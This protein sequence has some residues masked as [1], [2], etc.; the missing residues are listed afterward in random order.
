MT[1]TVKDVTGTV[2]TP[3]SPVDKIVDGVTGTLDE[4]TKKLVPEEQD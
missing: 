2:A 3:G 1:G 4:T